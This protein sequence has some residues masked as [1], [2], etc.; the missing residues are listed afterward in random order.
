MTEKTM[1]IMMLL[2]IKGIGGQSVQKIMPLLSDFTRAVDKWETIGKIP[3]PTINKAVT[4]GK[5]S[6][7]TWGKAYLDVTEEL[8]QA[9]KLNIKILNYLDTA[10]P[11]QLLKLKHFPVIV[12]VKGNIKLLNAPKRIAIVGTRTPST[13]AIDTEIQITKQVSQL[14][15]VVISGL[16]KGCDTYAHR[17][18]KETIAVLAHGLDRPTYPAQNATLAARIL[19][20]GGT[21]FSTY[22]LGTKL[23]PAYLAARD[24]WESGLSDGVIVVETGATG[25]TQITID[26]A[27]KQGKPLGVLR[28]QQAQV[29]NFRNDPVIEVISNRKTL[30]N[31]LKKIQT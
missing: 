25:G 16:A 28:F 20:Q 18:A 5:L 27:R 15:Y 8:K 17:F 31:F 11:Q 29:D 12:Y 10:Y 2:R 24:E 3:L 21:L 6:A 9:K 7:Q 1:L 19:E 23:K 30:S 22:P 4:S 13:A 14:G 26:F